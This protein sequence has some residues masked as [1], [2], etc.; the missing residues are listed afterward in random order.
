ML[1]SQI[2]SKKNQINFIKIKF[3]E[4]DVKLNNM[5]KIRQNICACNGLVS[6]N[7]R[8]AKKEMEIKFRT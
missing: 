1:P 6:K 7:E 2:E 3:S 5:I 8:F 4:G